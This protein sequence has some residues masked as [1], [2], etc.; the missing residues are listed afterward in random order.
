MKVNQTSIPSIYQAVQLAATQLANSDSPLLDARV[1]LCHVLNCSTT[2]LHTYPEKKLTPDDWLHFTDLVE[3]RDTG[4]PI[5]H[6]VGYKE[7]WSLRLK[8]NA[9]T[10]IPRPETEL[11]IE[12]ALDLVLPDTARVLDLGTGT[13]AIALSIATEKP[14]WRVTGSDF[15]PQIVQL[16]QENGLLNQIDNVTWLTSSWFSNIPAQSFDLI[17]SNPPYIDKNDHHLNQGDVKFEPASALI[18]DKNGLSDIET[19]VQTSPQY[20]S[21][22]GWLL[23][24][25]GFEQGEEVR[26]LLT[27]NGFMNVKTHQDLAGLD[28]VTIGQSSS[29]I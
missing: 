15:D 20:L 24:E 27:Q 22:E 9:T 29:R 26:D 25:H 8:V 2:Y 5:A 11:I 3:E 28:R 10:L 6:L 7:F 17:V 14:S 21:C 18:A 13:G 1:L 23:L 12:L 19:I 16:A 4:I